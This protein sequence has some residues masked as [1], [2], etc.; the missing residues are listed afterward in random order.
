M[1]F[2][3]YVSSPDVLDQNARIS[4][5]PQILNLTFPEEHWLKRVRVST[6]RISFHSWKES[7]PLDVKEQ[8]QEIYSLLTLQIS[9]YCKK[10]ETKHYHS[11]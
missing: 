6:K 1:P 5:S 3:H 2:T 11:I 7:K 10:G 9:I 8:V 4:Y